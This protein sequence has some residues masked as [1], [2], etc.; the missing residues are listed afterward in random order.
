MNKKFCLAVLSVSLIY[1]NALYGGIPGTCPDVPLGWKGTTALEGWAID[2]KYA[3]RIQLEK[4]YVCLNSWLYMP[5]KRKPAACEYAIEG[6]KNKKVSLILTIAGK[7]TSTT[8]FDP[9]LDLVFD[10]KNQGYQC[11]SKTGSTA[12]CQ[13]LDG[14]YTHM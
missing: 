1:G 11:T 3:P 12:D 9:K 6:D 8:H 10:E 14:G 5:K 4:K 7:N 13:F 2:E